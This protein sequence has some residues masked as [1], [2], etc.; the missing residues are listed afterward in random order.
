MR[1]HSVPII[2]QLGLAHQKCRPVHASFDSYAA[3]V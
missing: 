2:T 3:S 1:Y